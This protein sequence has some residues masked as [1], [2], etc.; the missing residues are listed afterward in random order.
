MR[1]VLVLELSFCCDFLKCFS[2]ICPLRSY[3]KTRS[4]GGAWHLP[5]LILFV[6]YLLLL[7]VFVIIRFACYSVRYYWTVLLNLRN[8]HTHRISLSHSV[9]SLFAFGSFCNIQLPSRILRRQS[10]QICFQN[11]CWCGGCVCV[12]YVCVYVCR[13]YDLNVRVLG[14]KGQRTCVVTIPSFAQTNTIVM[15]NTQT[16]QCH[17]ITF[18]VPKL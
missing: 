8:W 18:N 17:P 10:G 4:D 6:W 7:V 2:L 15:L 16:L 1:I 9:F 13:W 3:W 11:Y 14:E 12:I 5:H